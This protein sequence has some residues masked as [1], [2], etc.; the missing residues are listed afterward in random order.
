MFKNL[1]KKA[2]N[3]VKNSWKKFK[4]F[5]SR[6]FKG[7]PAESKIETKEE[8]KEI[9][10]EAAKE[11]TKKCIG[12]NWSNNTK[13]EIKDEAAKEETKKC[14][15]LG[16]YSRKEEV[17]EIKDEA[18]KEETKTVKKEEVKEIKDETNE[19]NVLNILTNAQ[20]ETIE[21][22]EYALLAV[23]T[24]EKES[25]DFYSELS[26]KSKAEGF[27]KNLVRAKEKL[28]GKKLPKS[29]VNQIVKAIR[30]DKNFLAT[31][32]YRKDVAQALNSGEM[33][34]VLGK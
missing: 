20:N 1:F 16:W 2:M 33:F 8:V 34:I 22:V 3:F 32:E 27:A 26:S 10:D 13:E 7:K 12:I 11:E 19:I 31:E 24:D 6:I 23:S 21:N 4:N 29:K 17:K 28:S 30:Q 25:N 9:K 18:A 15:G 5:V 14:I